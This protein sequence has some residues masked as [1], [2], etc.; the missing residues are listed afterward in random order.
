MGLPNHVKHTLQLFLRK[1]EITIEEA[2]VTAMW[3]FETDI[4]SSNIL[5]TLAVTGSP[6]L[7]IMPETTKVCFNHLQRGANKFL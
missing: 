6:E 7:I 2:V 1:D 5:P 4:P 3:T